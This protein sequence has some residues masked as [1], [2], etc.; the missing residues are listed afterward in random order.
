MEI[1]IGQIWKIKNITT[2]PN[3]VI[4]DADKYSTKVYWKYVET[5][6]VFEVE[7]ERFLKDFE[8]VS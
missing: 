8:R 6:S 2:R 7:K 1:E 5:S 3:V 4:V